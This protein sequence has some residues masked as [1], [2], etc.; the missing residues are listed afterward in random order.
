[1]DECFKCEISES[2]MLLFEVVTYEGILKICR[3]CSLK[4]NF[5]AIKHEIEN[6]E[7]TERKPRGLI[8]TQATKKSSAIDYEQRSKH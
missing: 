8:V 6:L 2:R 5:P 1:M 7:K 3:K 4:E